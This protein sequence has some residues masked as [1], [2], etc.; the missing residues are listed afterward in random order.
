[1]NTVL[2]EQGSWGREIPIQDL[3]D[4]AEILS[5]GHAKITLLRRAYNDRDLSAIFGLCDND[6]LRQ[7]VMEDNLRSLFRV[8]ESYEPVI[9]DHDDLR[10]AV[11]EHN[12]HSIFRVLEHFEP[13]VGNHDDLRRAVVEHNLHSLFRCLD[14][15]TPLIGDHED[16]RKAIMDRNL[17]SLFRVLEN[18][19]VDTEVTA[20]T[21]RRAVI[22]QDLNSILRLFDQGS[23]FKRAV[24]D[25]SLRSI[26]SLFDGC[27]D[28]KRSVIDRDLWAIFRLFAD[29]DDIKKAVINQDLY[30]IFKIYQGADD[31]KKAV[32][33]KDLWAIFR[34]LQQPD[35]KNLVM[36]Q[37]RTSMYRLLDSY[38]PSAIID[39]IK[40]LE[41]AGTEFSFDCVSRGQLKS[42]LWLIEVLRNLNVDLGCVFLCAGWYATLAVML[43]ETELSIEKIRSFDVDPNVADVAEKFNRKWVQDSWKFKAFTKDIMKVNYVAEENHCKNSE[44]STATIC[45][46]PD[47]VI[48]TSCEHIKYF[49]LWYDKIPKGLLVVLQTNDLKDVEDH[50]NCC[51]TLAEFEMKTP[52]DRTL[53]Q[54]ELDLGNYKRFMRIGIK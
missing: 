7:A 24:K 29:T 41:N 54:G 35:T 2:E 44:G 38:Y 18:L 47:T 33:G 32:I 52:M 19:P 22:D 28:L 43:F 6:D 13:V 3:L 46:S 51:E 50:V 8:L 17:H 16:L 26:F 27:E 36:N 23:D 5:G 12:L 49:D 39:C 21:L 10:R 20:K 37:S 45:D 48:N 53:F 40:A 1:M 25:Q 15:Y 14:D 42:K 31:V 30:A 9:S 4:R 11:V 34:L